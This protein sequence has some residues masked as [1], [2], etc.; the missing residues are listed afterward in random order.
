[1]KEL[2]KTEISRYGR[3]SATNYSDEIQ[4]AYIKKKTDITEKSHE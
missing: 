4:G 3:E 2:I 1:M